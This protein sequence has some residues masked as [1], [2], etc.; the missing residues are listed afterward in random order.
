MYNS[1]FWRKSNNLI[2][3]T[4]QSNETIDSALK[5]FNLKVQQSGVLRD[6][7]EHA[8][9][10]KPSEKRRRAKRRSRRPL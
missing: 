7:K 8:H 4:V 10:E 3:V 5:R 9:Y 6:L 1:G 2:H